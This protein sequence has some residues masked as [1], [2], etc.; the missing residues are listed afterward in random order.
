MKISSNNGVP[1]PQAHVAIN[2]SRLKI[3]NK[4]S[5]TPTFYLQKGQEFQLELFNPTSG[6][7]LAK[8]FL[9][10][11]TISQGGLVLRP[12]E[13][14]FLDRYI[15]VPKKFLFDTYDVANTSE[16]KKA[17]EDNGDFKV[18]FYKEHI[19]TYNISVTPSI[20]TYFNQN[21]D[22]W[23]GNIGTNYKDTIYG[24]TSYD[25]NAS[26]NST[27]SLSDGL[28][29]FSTTSFSDNS[30]DLSNKPRSLARKSKTIETGRVEKG[31]TSDQKLTTVNK[32]W[33]YFPFYTVE[34]KLLPVSQ[35]INTTDDI[36]VKRYCT[37]CGSKLGKTHKFC[38]NCGA[39]A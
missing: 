37:N 8:I 31:S 15:D 17:I 6:T 32:Y 4:D 11:N 33:E 19:P 24:D 23:R 14:V 22:M 20:H 5:K 34:Y 9:N 27:S 3:Y 18:E 35:K 29:L 28:S 26:L 39:K 30:L 1:T 12:G 10:G 16:V 13:R 21:N 2:K 36:N 25:I 38:A 7:V